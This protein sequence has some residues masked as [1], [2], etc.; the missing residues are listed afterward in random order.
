MT[1][2]TVDIDI[3]NFRT[4][5]ILAVVMMVFGAMIGAGIYVTF[6]GLNITF[7]KGI[8]VIVILFI[9]C[10]IIAYIPYL[11]RDWRMKWGRFAPEE[12]EE[13]YIEISEEWLP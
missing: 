8:A 7:D 1:D 6:S 9:T 10:G 4:F 3:T 12:E 2:D 11:Y 13:D 5:V